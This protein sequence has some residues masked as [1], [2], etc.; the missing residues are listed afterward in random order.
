MENDIESFV[1]I[2]QAQF[3]I[4]DI[5]KYDK[6]LREALIGNKQAKIFFEK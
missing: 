5:S 3:K 2:V 6:N 4:Y 1:Q